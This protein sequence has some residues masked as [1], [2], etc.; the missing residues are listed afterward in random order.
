MVCG[1]AIN[2]LKITLILQPAL[3]GFKI[4]L[5]CAHGNKLH[6]ARCSF[7]FEYLIVK[8]SWFENKTQNSQVLIV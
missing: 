4:G 7:Y 3:G 8:S 5:S 2:S 6:E 1:V